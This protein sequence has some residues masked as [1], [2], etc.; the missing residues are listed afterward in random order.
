M[1]LLCQTGR[2]QEQTPPSLNAFYCSFQAG[3]LV[4]AVPGTSTIDEGKN[5]QWKFPSLI[6]GARTRGELQDLLVDSFPYYDPLPN[7]NIF[8]QLKVFRSTEHQ[9]CAN[10]SNFQSLHQA[11]FTLLFF[12][13]SSTF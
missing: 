5:K 10:L 12:I 13:V 2:P 3:P 6:T 7:I 1:Q 4:K 11:S 8:L 9:T